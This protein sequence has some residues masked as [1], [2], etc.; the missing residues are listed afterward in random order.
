[1]DWTKF[2]RLRVITGTTLS[3][4]WPH[5][6]AYILTVVAQSELQLN[7]L[8]ESHVRRLEN[9]TIGSALAAEFSFLD[10]IPT[11]VQNVDFG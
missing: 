3:I 7:P 4:N 11:T 6:V 2:D 9:W 1:M 8:F 10:C 5:G